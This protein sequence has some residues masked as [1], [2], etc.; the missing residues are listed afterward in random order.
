VSVLPIAVSGHPTLHHLA[1]PVTDVTADIVQLVSDMTDTMHAAPGVG[2]AAPQVGVSLQIF[3]W[4]YDDGS[5]LHEGHVLNP[6][7]RVSGW[8]RH[9]LCGEPEEEGCLSLPG[10][11]SPLARYPRARLQGRD[12][13]GQ[14]VDILAE[15]WLARIFQH[16]YDHVRGVLYADR[17]STTRRRNILTESASAGFGTALISWTPGVDGE[18]GD[19]VTDNDPAHP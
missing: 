1:T 11:R 3:V 2:L 16:E 8:P 19:F 13:E 10:L 4:H 14:P 9:L 17:L 6:R 7:L 18:E 15:G 5:Q 12:L